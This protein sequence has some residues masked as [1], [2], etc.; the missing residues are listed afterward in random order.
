MVVYCGQYLSQSMRHHAARASAV[1]LAT[2]RLRR[3]CEQ[4]QWKSSK[5][6]KDDMKK[7]RRV[8]AMGQVLCGPTL[9]LPLL[10][11]DLLHMYAG[12]HS[13]CLV[14][15]CTCAVFFRLHLCAA[16]MWWQLAFLG[17]P[18]WERKQLLDRILVGQRASLQP[19]P[20]G[21]MFRCRFCGLLQQHG[22][23]M[24]Q[25]LR[26]CHPDSSWIYARQR[27]KYEPEHLRRAI[28]DSASPVIT[29]LKVGA[30]AFAG[31]ALRQRGSIVAS[32]ETARAYAA[33]FANLLAH[34]AWGETIGAAE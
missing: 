15:Q 33:V 7:L 32:L 11:N 6:C 22:K 29:R 14:L 16:Q 2:G 26:V 18:Q 1:L 17:C 28:V 23:S 12:Y 5:Q 4:K 3:L 34:V 8:R 21:W 19:A 20:I 10:V 25:H 24:V 27:E 30:D 9:L 31:L 13:G